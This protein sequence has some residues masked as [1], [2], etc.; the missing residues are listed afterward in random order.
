MR[1]EQER[2]AGDASSVPCRN[3]FLSCGDGAPKA[4]TP[5]LLG[6]R[7]RC[8]S[9]LGSFVTDMATRTSDPAEI[10]GY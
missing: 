1:A 8:V 5:A 10:S 3:G 9:A 2:K 4:P 6:A 7:V